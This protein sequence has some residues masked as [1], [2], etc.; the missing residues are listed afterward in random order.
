MNTDC[1][2]MAQPVSPQVA[3]RCAVDL[4]GSQSAMGRLLGVSQRAV[5]RWVRENKILPA[6][7]VLKVEAATGISR[8][9]LRP[10]LYPRDETPA[11][12]PQETAA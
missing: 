6:E 9:L 2:D 4:I 10:D 12:E 1:P 8:H 5:W 7:H 11:P 3:L